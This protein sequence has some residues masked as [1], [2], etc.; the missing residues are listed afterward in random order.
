MKTFSGNSPPFYTSPNHNRVS[1]FQQQPLTVSASRIDDPDAGYFGYYNQLAHQQNMLQDTART[2]AYHRAIMANAE[3]FEGKVVMDLG[4]GSGILSFFAAQA[5]AARVYAIEAAPGM[6]RM[7][8]RLVQANGY[9]GVIHVIQG[10]IETLPSDAVPEPVDILISEPMGVL[11]VHER[12]LESFLYARD[13]FLRPPVEE[14]SMWPSS[15]TIHFAP[16]SDI[17]LYAE[18][19]GKARFWEDRSFFGVDLSV[20]A[21][22]AVEEA[23]GRP[24]V[25]PFEARSL[26]AVAVS[27]ELPFWTMPSS[28]L[29]RFT[30]PLRFVA[31]STGILHGIA[32]WFDTRF[33][34]PDARLAS[35]LSTAPDA[36]GTHWYQTRFLFPRPLA[37]NQGQVLMGTIEFRAN[38]SRSYDIG[39]SMH[40]E[41]TEIRVDNCNQAIRYRLQDQVYWNLANLSTGNSVNLQPEQF[42]IYSTPP[43]TNGT[44]INPQALLLDDELLDF[45][46][47]DDEEMVTTF[48]VSPQ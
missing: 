17:L 13:R 2:T 32:C 27:H 7:A 9:E 47:E 19:M 38:P 20:L 37:I 39:L 22:E 31:H 12:M 21:E 45:L 15:G 41:G 40:L 43:N 36:E 23:M 26:L 33:V 8:R 29:Q 11:L 35:L 6:A 30:V 14:A 24:V 3:H 48:T 34:G 10:R 28:Q 18:T 46:P 42:G 25:G 4:C 1:S 44:T 16:F 5:G